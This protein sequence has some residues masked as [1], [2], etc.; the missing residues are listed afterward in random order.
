MWQPIHCNRRDSRIADPDL[1]VTGEKM[2][3]A[4]TNSCLFSF[5]PRLWIWP[6]Q[7]FPALTSHQCWA[8]AWNWELRHSLCP[9]CFYYG[10]SITAR[11][12]ASKSAS[13]TTMFV[14]P[15]FL[16]QLRI[17]SPYIP[18]PSYHFAL[19][20]SAPSE[21]LTAGKHSRSTISTSFYPVICTKNVVQALCMG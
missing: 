19:C 10:V 1:L 16:K 7:V 20:P 2:N 8:A 21:Y 3:W 12:N 15:S 17:P 6:S 18:S 13:K 11:G 5:C 4:Q 14:L 9:R